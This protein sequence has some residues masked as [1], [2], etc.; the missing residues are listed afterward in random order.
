MINF[1]ALAVIAAAV[2][3]PVTTFAQSLPFLNISPDAASQAMAGASVASE[4]SAFA[5][6][7]NASAVALSEDNFAVG[8]SLNTWNVS[9]V[10]NKMISAGA[11]FKV[12]DKIGIA[13]SYRSFENPEYSMYDDQC[14]YLGEYT[15]VDSSIDIA[16]AYAISDNLSIGVTYKTISSKLSDS[17][18]GSASGFDLGATYKLDLLTVGASLSNIG[19]ISYDGGSENS[20]PTI[21][22][23]GASYKAL[24]SDLLDVLFNAQAEYLTEESAL[25]VALGAQCT[26]FNSI[27]ARAGYY[28][29]G[30]ETIMPSYLSLGAGL[31][32]SFCSINASYLVSEMLG[33]S[34]NLSV[35]VKF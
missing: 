9:E 32:I 24:D 20:L 34:L 2:V 28:V 25:G 14:A 7:N 12:T 35:G 13:A 29:S 33:G 17:Y 18:S 5:I 10:S 8:A 22:K 3:I 27:S 19:S 31:D 30:D 6:Y 1:K 23:A 15:P 16:L 26:I 4:A 21:A 11:F